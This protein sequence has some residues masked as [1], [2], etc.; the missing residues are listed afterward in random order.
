MRTAIIVLGVVLIGLGAAIGFGRLSYPDE[1]SVV[2]LGSL[3]AVMTRQRPIPPWLGAVTALTG[4][5]IALLGT[6]YRR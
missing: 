4:I 3:S 5:A 6:K 1:K 2:K